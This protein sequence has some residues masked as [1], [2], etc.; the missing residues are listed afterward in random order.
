MTETFF[1]VFFLFLLF[2]GLVTKLHKAM[3]MTS[4]V[5]PWT[6]MSFYLCQLFYQ[7][8][9]DILGAHSSYVLVGI[10]GVCLSSLRVL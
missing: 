2:V 1:F 5:S 8:M 6:I 4:V 9:F 3:A 10:M 7:A